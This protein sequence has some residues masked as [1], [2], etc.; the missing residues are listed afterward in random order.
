MVV[1]EKLTKEINFIPV[2]LIVKASKII[3]MFAKT[4]TRLH[5][6]PKEVRLIHDAKLTS[7]FLM[8]FLRVLR[9]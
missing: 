5:G 6:V 3:K 7:R 9:T 1:V 8:N 4:I 2:F